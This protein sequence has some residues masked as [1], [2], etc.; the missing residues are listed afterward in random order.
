MN[1]ERVLIPTDLSDEANAALES[2]DLF[3]ENF[4]CT[5]DLMHVIPLSKYLGDSFDKL[6]IPLSID[7]DVYPKLI[8]NQRKELSAFANKHIKKKEKRGEYIVTIDR[9]PSDSILSQIEKGKYDLVMMSAKGG[10]YSDFFHG[11][12]TDKIIRRSKT[13]VLTLSKKMKAEKVNKILVPC[14]FSDHSL[15]AI[16]M[17]FDIARKFG[18]SLE[19]LNVI[20]LYAADVHGIE[21]VSIGVDNS[22]VYGGLKSR[23]KKFFGKYEDHD[24]SIEDGEGEFEDVLVHKENGTTSSVNFKTVILKSVAAHHEIIDYA[25][26]NADLVVMSTHGRTG[27]S[28][29]LLGSTTEQVIQHL[30]KPQIT[31]KP[32][33]K[34]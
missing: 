10:H 22:A 23:L 25:N 3:I 15:A 11:S 1:V 20:E 7:K 31:I 24:F 16:P 32:E 13:P 18:A 26:D 8:E 34:K 14:D 5:V 6:G 9:K 4:D 29:M 33:L 30:E 12:A 21:P 28:R 27:L 19:I 2:A 17:A